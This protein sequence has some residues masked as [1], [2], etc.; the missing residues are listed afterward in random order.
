MIVLYRSTLLSSDAGDFLLMTQ[1]KSFTF[2]S[3]CFLFWLNVVP[4]LA[5]NPNVGHFVLMVV[6]NY[7]TF[8]SILT[9]WWVW[10]VWCWKYLVERP[11]RFQRDDSSASGRSFALYE[12]LSSSY[13]SLSLLHKPTKRRTLDREIC[14]SVT[15]V[16]LPYFV[17][18]ECHDNEHVL[19]LE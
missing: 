18:L 10:W 7:W 2:R 13:G 9:V 5:W 8:S 17:L 11:V 1:Y 4:T 15:V 16:T 6:I 19:S 14:R 3:I 12:L